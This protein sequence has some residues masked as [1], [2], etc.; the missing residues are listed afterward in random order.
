MGST[1]KINNLSKSFDGIRALE[2]VSFDI[3]DGKIT[4]VIGPNGAGKKTLFNV[5]TGCIKPSTGEI[6]Y[7]G[8]SLHA[9]SPHKIARLGLGRTFQN[10][11]LFQQITVMDNLLLA[12][13]YPTGERLWAAL[14]RPW[15]ML[16]EEQ[17]NREKALALLELV[18]LE[19]KTVAMAEDL[20][21]GQRKLVEIVRILALDS[22]VL[23]LDE[24]IAGLYPEMI[25][26]MKKTI[27]QL[28]AQGKTILF[29]EHNI[30]VVMDI[31]DHII[32]LNHGEKIAEGLPEAIKEDAR[33]IEAYLG[34]R[35]H[36]TP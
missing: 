36:A 17:A 32:V 14:A 2:N 33:V 22:Q 29:I 1:L 28:S 5:L 19:E 4:A 13:Q 20:S 3:P 16:E 30:N 8:H 23:L 11:R 15:T 6:Q 27:R 35:Q 25:E 34:R 18:G 21:Y 26:T 12:M 31:S 24:P 7:D 10:V 9:M